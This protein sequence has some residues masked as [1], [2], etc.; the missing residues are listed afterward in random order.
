MSFLY[1]KGDL[2]VVEDEDLLKVEKRVK[3]VILQ[4]KGGACRVCCSLLRGARKVHCPVGGG[5]LEFHHKL[6]IKSDGLYIGQYRLAAKEE[7]RWDGLKKLE[8]EA[9]LVE[10]LCQVHH[11][12]VHS[13][14]R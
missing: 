13:L 3:E 7:A 10:L 12:W 11:G 4:R 5:R 9:E 8:A 1:R 6:G 14:D 2:E